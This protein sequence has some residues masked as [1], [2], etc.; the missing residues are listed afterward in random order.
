MQ[1]FP[2]CSLPASHPPQHREAAAQHPGYLSKSYS[3][4][5]TCY[6]L[7]LQLEENEACQL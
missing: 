7:A 6:Y 1:S 3:S 4:G 5:L 2:P